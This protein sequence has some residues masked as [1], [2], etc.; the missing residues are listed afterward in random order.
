MKRRVASG[1]DSEGGTAELS[2]FDGFWGI[3]LLIGL[4]S[5][6]GAAWTRLDKTHSRISMALNVAFGLAIVVSIFALILPIFWRK[7]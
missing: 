3:V 5:L 1:G 4:V 7:P 2:I 6:A